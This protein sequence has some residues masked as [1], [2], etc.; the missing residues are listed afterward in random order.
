M[1]KQQ[2]KSKEETVIVAQTASGGNN[3]STLD[4]LTFHTSIT[5]TILAVICVILLLVVL[6]LG[7]RQY[8]KCHRRWIQRGIQEHTLRRTSSWFR[9]QRGQGGDRDDRGDRAG[10]KIGV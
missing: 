6:Y 1:G 9:R 10:I 4:H 5:T 7:Y 2:S 3:L 8:G